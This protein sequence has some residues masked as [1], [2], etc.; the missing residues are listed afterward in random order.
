MA[1]VAVMMAHVFVHRDA[2][3]VPSE[4][5]AAQHSTPHAAMRPKKPSSEPQNMKLKKSSQ[6]AE[7]RTRR[8]SG[9]RSTYMRARPCDESCGA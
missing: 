5:G 9:S 1:I 6:Q 8:A 4:P 3:A 7:E 2:Y